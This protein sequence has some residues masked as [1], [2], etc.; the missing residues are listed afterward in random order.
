MAVK[1]GYTNVMVYRQGILGWAKSGRPLEST[2]SYPEVNIPIIS[3]LDLQSGKAPGTM[4]LDIRPKS[5]YDKGHIEGSLN[6]DLEDLDLQLNRLPE[7]R[8]IV[9]VD[10]KGKLT[11]TTGRFLFS[12]GFQEVLRLD[13]GFNAWVKNGMPIDK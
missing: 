7:N 4:I 9:I 5:H 3:S 1:I 6:I 11:L 13:G 12:K 10:H 2:A 8:P